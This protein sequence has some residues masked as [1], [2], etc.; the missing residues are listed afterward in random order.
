LCDGTDV[1]KPKSSSER[2][3]KT[4]IFSNLVAWRY[5]WKYNE[6]SD[7]ILAESPMTEITESKILPHDGIDTEKIDVSLLKILQRYG[8]LLEINRILSKFGSVEVLVGIK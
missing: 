1:E 5:W 6:R 3:E 8:Y 4:E 2:C 7:K